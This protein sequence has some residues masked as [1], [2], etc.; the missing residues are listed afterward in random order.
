VWRTDVKVVDKITTP[1][2]QLSTVAKFAVD[3]RRPGL[4]NA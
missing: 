3:R 1:G 2:G 4:S